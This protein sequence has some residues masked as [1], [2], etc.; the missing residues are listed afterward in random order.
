M[1][2]QVTSSDT[3]VQGD[4]NFLLKFF[5]Y[6]LLDMILL[7]G[8]LCIEPAKNAIADLY[9]IPYLQQMSGILVCSTHI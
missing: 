7:V 5:G 6:N 8:C 4:E 3:L 2:P 1:Y 9:L